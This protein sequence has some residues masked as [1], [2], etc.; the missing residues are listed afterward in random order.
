M[1]IYISKVGANP[2]LVA[3]INSLNTGKTLQLDYLQFGGLSSNPMKLSSSNILV[4]APSE[5]C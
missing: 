2:A 3:H 1:S 4:Q 5:M